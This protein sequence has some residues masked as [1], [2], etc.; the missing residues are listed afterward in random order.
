MQIGDIGSIH[1]SIDR[2]FL[3]RSN[4][5]WMDTVHWT[6]AIFQRTVVS[7]RGSCGRTA[8]IHQRPN[9]RFLYQLFSHGLQYNPIHP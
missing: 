9:E 3:Q 2:S 1:P 8:A 4:T 5:W 7:R 6:A